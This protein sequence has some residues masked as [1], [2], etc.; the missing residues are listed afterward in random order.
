M[1][2]FSRMVTAGAVILGVGSATAQAG[3]ITA[4]SIEFDTGVTFQ[5]TSVSLDG[6]GDYGVTIFDLNGTVGYFISPRIEVTGG[7]LIEHLSVDDVSTTGMG[8]E[9]GGYYHFRT[10]G[11]VV[12]FAGIALGFLSHGGD[13]PDDTELIFPELSGGVRFPFRDVAS[14]NL[15]GGYRHR[16]SAFGIDDAGGN[17]IFLGFGFSLFFRGGFAGQSTR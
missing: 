15:F 11:D 5:H 16:S 2:T 8:L 3:S 9:F 6:P 12:P 10:S 7:L 17:D 14:L 13:G 1:K 4:K